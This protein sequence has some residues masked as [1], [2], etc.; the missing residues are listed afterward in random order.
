MPANP[1][2]AAEDLTEPY[3]AAR[4]ELDAYDV[5]ATS[6][7]GSSKL[8][9]AHFRRDRPSLGMTTPNDRSDE[10]MAV[11]NL[12]PQ[13]GN[14]IWC[15][16][17]NDRRVGMSRGALAVLDHRAA[18]TTRMLEPFET[19][20]IFLPVEDLR[21]FSREVGRRPIET[22]HCPLTS[23][24]ED[25]VML[26]LGLALLPAIQNPD[27]V[28]TLYADHMYGAIRLHLA[29]NY[30]GLVLPE[31]R[32]RGGL[33][34]WQERL[35][36]ELLLD[37]LQCDTGMSELAEACQ[38]SERHFRR[39]FRQTHGAPPHRWLLQQKVERAKHLL[40]RTGNP[41]SDV[42]QECGFADQSHLSRVFKAR[43]GTSPA[44]W[45]RQR[46]M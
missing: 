35:V 8:V 1:A 34:P 16:G 3:F 9:A 42:A 30:G 14:E 6:R 32:S 37:D 43:V 7:L 29:L 13:N 21:K 2:A 33:A 38:V 28:S 44:A 23:V 12:R 41:I 45:R 10:L 18:W 39:A 15:D 25:P 46:R 5:F 11:V 24:Q 20:H 31:E 36:R 19:I 40:E 22:L 26:H 27:E 4:E 17:R